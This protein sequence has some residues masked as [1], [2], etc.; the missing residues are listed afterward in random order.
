MNIGE[1]I[2]RARKARNW[3]Q[4]QLAVAAG[5]AVNTVVKIERGKDAKQ[6]TLAKLTNA[7]DLDLRI[8]AVDRRA[9]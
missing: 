6:S 4:P 8:T 1:R 7:L 3:S 5:V 9:A 2:K